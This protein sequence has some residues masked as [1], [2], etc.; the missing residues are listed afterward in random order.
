MKGS[1]TIEA[2]LICPWILFSVIMLWYLGFFQHNRVV[3]SAICKEAAY[4]GL[5]AVRCKED[6]EAGVQRVLDDR[7]NWL[8]GNPH[9]ETEVNISR[10]EIQV[11]VNMEMEFPFIF[12]KGTEMG[13]V[14]ELSEEM[15]LPIVEPVR[16][17]RTLRSLEEF[18]NTLA[19]EDEEGDVS[20]AGRIQTGINKKYA[21][22]EG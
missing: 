22:V 21:G 18:N 16:N 17:I 9:I 14:W 11:C 20:G 7:L 10:S 2:A 8:P 15:T 3:C 19:G 13:E 5:E 4:A 1:Y 12:W 6:V